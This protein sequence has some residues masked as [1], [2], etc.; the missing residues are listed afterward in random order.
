MRSWRSTV[1]ASVAI[2]IHCS[3][4]RLHAR[5]W[6][7]LNNVT[8]LA[9]VLMVGVVIDDAIVVLENIFHCIEEKGMAPRE[10][11]VHGTQEIGLAVLATTLS[12]GNRLSPASLFPRHATGACCFNS[13]R[14]GHGCHPRFDVRQ[15][16][17]DSDD[18]QPSPQER[19]TEPGRG[20]SSSIEAG[21]LRTVEVTYLWM[22]R[23]AMRWRWLVLVVSICVMASNVPLYRL[24]KQDYIPLNV[25]ESEFE[26]RVEARQGASL[27]AMRHWI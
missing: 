16:Y 26:V 6:F 10:A 4:V 14:Y 19:I 11:A 22:L 3:H 20:R 9:L 5:S 21:G 24:V 13:E 8:M 7:T 18:V 17:T 2:P 25:D 12:L 1:I 15:F 27:A 23:H